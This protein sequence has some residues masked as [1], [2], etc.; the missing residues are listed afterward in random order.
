[1]R[2]YLYY[3]WPFIE[4]P[5]NFHLV[6]VDAIVAVIVAIVGAVFFSVVVDIIIVV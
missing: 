3:F 6:V 2:Y 5:N 4:N 1:M